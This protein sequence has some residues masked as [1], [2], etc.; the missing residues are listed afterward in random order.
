R[1]QLHGCTAEGLGVDG[2]APVPD[3]ASGQWEADGHSLGTLSGF[4][5]GLLERTGLETS[6]AERADYVRIEFR[7]VPEFPIEPEHL[8]A[9]YWA[10][11]LK[12]RPFCEPPAS[13]L[14][15]SD[16]PPGPTPARA[17]VR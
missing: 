13:P 8:R 6:D 4:H 2:V 11:T 12:A 16:P 1:Y 3:G 9:L 17:Y 15:S 5:I 7:L 10:T 14:I